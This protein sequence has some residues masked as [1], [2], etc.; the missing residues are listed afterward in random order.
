[1][2]CVNIIVLSWAELY[3]GS[4]GAVKFSRKMLARY[5]QKVFSVCGSDV[6]GIA[7]C[8]SQ[9]TKIQR[10]SFTSPVRSL[11][12]LIKNA[13]LQYSVTAVALK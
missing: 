5:C 13:C 1:M 10:Q 7:A 8:L 2:Q 3:T 12:C 4:L 11:S 6:N 9:N